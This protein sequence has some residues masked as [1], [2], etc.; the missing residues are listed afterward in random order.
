[1]SWEVVMLSIFILLAI[2]SL[3]RSYY[4][5]G[6]SRAPVNLTEAHISFV[7]I[8]LVICFYVH[9]IFKIS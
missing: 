7:L 3:A 5:V 1:M 9:L 4:A 8:I 2:A 6:K